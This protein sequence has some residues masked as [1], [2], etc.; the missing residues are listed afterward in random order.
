MATTQQDSPP[1]HPAELDGPAFFVS[2]FNLSA[3]SNEVVLVGN[4]LFPTWSGRRGGA[5][6]GAALAPRDPAQPAIGQR[7]IRLPGGPNR[8]LIMLGTGHVIHGCLRS[9]MI[10]GADNVSAGDLDPRFEG[11]LGAA[12]PGG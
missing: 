8:Q 9:A 3:T 7:P 11:N 12:E 2:S 1:P 6:A 10:M 4:E 5:T